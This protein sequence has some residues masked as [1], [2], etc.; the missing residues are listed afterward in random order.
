MQVFLG[1]ELLGFRLDLVDDGQPFGG[2]FLI[3][4]HGVSQK[5]GGKD[6]PDG[7]VVEIKRAFDNA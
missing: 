1:N 6:I 2:S 3:G 4:R 7:L 5:A